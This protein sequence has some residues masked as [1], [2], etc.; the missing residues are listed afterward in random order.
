MAATDN[1]HLAIGLADGG[2][3]VLVQRLARAARFFGS[4]QH[5]YAPHTRR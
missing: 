2:N 4:V 1:L 3:H 5:G